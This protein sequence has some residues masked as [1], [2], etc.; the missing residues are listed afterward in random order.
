MLFKS[1]C[2]AA[3][4]LANAPRQT[5]AAPDLSTAK[6]NSPIT[7]SASTNSSSQPCFEFDELYNLQKQFLNSFISPADQTQ[8]KSINSSLLSEDC[9]G[10]IDITRTFKGRE[11]NTEYLFGLFANLA[12]TPGSLS[13]LGVPV[14]YEILHFAANENVVSALTRSE[15]T[16]SRTK[17]LELMEKAGSCSTSPPSTKSSP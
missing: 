7:T 16:V 13:L 3:L 6:R 9:L 12:A 4:A 14:S 8:A 5:H 2:T 17:G 1:L 10:R 11:L 15:S